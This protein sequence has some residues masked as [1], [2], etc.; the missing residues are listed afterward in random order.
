LRKQF[1]TKKKAGQEFGKVF[2]TSS[3]SLAT[4]VHVDIMKVMA[5][6]Y[7]T[8]KQEIFVATPTSKP[9]LQ[10]KTKRVG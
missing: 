5:K 3:V 4:M 10:V 7:G 8:E 9:I 2:F 1:A 6:R